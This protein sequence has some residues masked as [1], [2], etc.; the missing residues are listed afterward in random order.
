[1]PYSDKKLGILAI[2]HYLRAAG[3]R[4]ITLPERID[5]LR[6]LV[7][8]VR[9]GHIPEDVFVHLNATLEESDE[10]GYS[11]RVRGLSDEGLIKTCQLM[12]SSMAK[13]GYEARFAAQCREHFAQC[14]DCHSQA[15]G[16]I[17]SSE[18]ARSLIRNLTNHLPKPE[19]DEETIQRIETK[20]MREID[21]RK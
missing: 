12:M 4:G 21:K 17:R 15:C 19:M 1:M 5:E 2:P 8:A 7:S 20:L 16:V 10:A 11:D 18:M 13:S 9:T 14:P 6:N 3:Q